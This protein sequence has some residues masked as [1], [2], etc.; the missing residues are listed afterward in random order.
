MAIAANTYTR[1]DQIGVREQL[2][3]IIYNITPEETPFLQR[4]GRGKLTNTFFEWQQDAL[5]AVDG[6]NYQIEGDDAPAALALTPTVRIGNGTQISR[7]VIVVSDTAE[8]V[9]TAG[10]ADEEAYQL[11]MKGVELRRDMETTLIATNQA[12]AAGSTSTPRKTGTMLAFVKTNVNKSAAG[13]AANP[14][15]TT[16]PNATRT[17]GTQRVFTE[18][19][20]KDVLKQVYVSGG[21]SK[22]VMVGPVNKMRASGFSG[23]AGLR[24]EVSGKGAATIYSAADVYVGDFDTVTFVSNRLQ[25]ERDA[26]VLDFSYIEVDYLRPFKKVPL[27]KTGDAEKSMLIVEYGLRVGT[28]KAEGLIADLTTT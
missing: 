14:S 11:A 13:G 27:A 7:K 9:D 28:E 6:A 8:Y 12:Y 2:S 25:R 4:A 15:Y 26:W 16:T 1:F 24:S 20:L 18:D 17:D 22:T 5:A 21:N 3:N 19:L 23:I 10:R